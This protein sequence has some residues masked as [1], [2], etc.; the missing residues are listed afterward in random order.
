[1]NCSCGSVHTVSHSVSV[2]G[3]VF[4]QRN[5]LL[6]RGRVPNVTAVTKGRKE[7]FYFLFFLLHLNSN[8]MKW[9]VSRGK[10]EGPG[11]SK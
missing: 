5:L 10:S 2:S 7:I 8:K 1:M 6:F 9:S 4:S 3:G 11:K